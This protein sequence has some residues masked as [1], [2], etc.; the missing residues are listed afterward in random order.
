MR[1]FRCFNVSFASL[2]SL[3]YL[4]SGRKSMMSLHLFSH[5]LGTQNVLEAHR[6]RLPGSQA[7][8]CKNLGSL[9]S[10]MVSC[11]GVASG[12]EMPLLKGGSCRSQMKC[13]HT[14]RRIHP[15]TCLLAPNRFHSDALFGTR[16]RMKFERSL[17][18]VARRVTP[19]R[20]LVWVLG[21]RVFGIRRIFRW[22]T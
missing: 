18:D 12:M 7:P 11:C 20:V 8:R 14:P 2:C 4:F 9:E 5:G 10:I 3:R 6:L 1:L 17:H 19:S 21:L 15:S 13:M 16:R 22:R